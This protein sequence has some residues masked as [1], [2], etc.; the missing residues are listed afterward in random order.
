MRKYKAIGTMGFDTKVMKNSLTHK[1][2]GFG[3]MAV[4]ATS[5][6]LKAQDVAPAATSKNHS[7]AAEIDANTLAIAK[8]ADVILP[9]GS[10]RPAGSMP[11]MAIVVVQP[12]TKP[13]VHPFWDRQ[14]QI[15]FAANGALAA[16]DFFVTR[17][18]LEHSG[19]EMNP[20]TRLMSGSTPALAANFALE[21]GGVMGV[22]YLF[23]KTG[24]HKL[25]RITSYVNL[26]GSAYAV[27][28]GMAHR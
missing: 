16:S 3:L 7:E 5:G 23:H 14:N 18:N 8:P 1:F 9:T 12:P 21:T 2:L 15:L 28:Y 25:E 17:W 19:K 11:A 4:L 13:A 20:V 26:G 27:C 10:P 24:H 6:L 22:S